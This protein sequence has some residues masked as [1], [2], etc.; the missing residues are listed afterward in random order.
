MYIALIKHAHISSDYKS[1]KV[2]LICQPSSS[3]A[4]WLRK[5]QNLPVFISSVLS[6]SLN[7]NIYQLKDFRALQMWIGGQCVPDAIGWS[8]TDS[9]SESLTAS[10]MR[11]ACGAQ[12]AGTRSRTPAFCGTA[13][14][15][16][17]GTMLSELL[18]ITV[19]FIGGVSSSSFFT[20]NHQ[21]QL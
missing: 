4:T 10:G 7:Q 1:G 17:N 8:E 21:F 15:T 9:C 6:F 19:W 14:F 11:T 12:R 18:F 20:G 16:A 2:W 5:Q 13:N 3:S